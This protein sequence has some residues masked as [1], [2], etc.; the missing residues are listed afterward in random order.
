MTWPS[1]TGV[2]AWPSRRSSG[3][4]GSSSRPSRRSR[5][6][7]PWCPRSWAPRASRPAGGTRS[8]S[9]TTRKGSPS[10]CTSCSRTPGP[11]SS[12][13]PASPRCTRITTSTWGASGR[14]SSTRRWR[15]GWFERRRQRRRM[16]M[17]APEPKVSMDDKASALQDVHTI[18]ALLALGGRRV[19]DVGCGDGAVARLL[20]SNGCRV[21]GIERDKELADLARDACESVIVADA[22]EV[23]LAE[24]GDEP[25]D[26]LLCLDVLQH[27]IDPVETLRRLGTC[28]VPDGRVVASLPNVAHGD[29]RL[30]LLGGAFPFTARELLD[31]GQ[32]RFFDRRA[33][34]VLISAAGLE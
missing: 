19:L 9:S 25:F 14:M 15:I 1:S 8:T 10:G 13:G 18:A 20:A 34:E 27:L 5:T 26:V 31:R 4:Q 3:G 30:E 11:G 7:S 2:R 22:E 16:P 6:A 33:V 29:V 32:L 21:W 12:A 23:D 17:I 28:L 24:L